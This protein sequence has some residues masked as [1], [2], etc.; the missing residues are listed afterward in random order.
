M[1]VLWLKVKLRLEVETGVPGI[2]LPSLELEL[3]IGLIIVASRWIYYRFS[4]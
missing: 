3:I 4:S 2:K 1:L